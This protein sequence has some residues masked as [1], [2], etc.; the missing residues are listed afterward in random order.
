VSPSQTIFGVTLVIAL[1]SLAA[2]T[3]RKQW[4]V[5]TE[6]NA[7]ITLSPEDR[8]YYR[9]QARRRLICAVLMILLG[10]LLIASFFMEGRAEELATAMQQ[11]R[12][13]GEPRDLTPAEHTFSQVYG[14]VWI[15][16]LLLLFWLIGLAGIDYLAIRQYGKRHYKLIQ[17][18]RREMI[19]EE[20]KRYRR[21]RSEMN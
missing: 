19:R 1:F 16:A 8:V 5:L 11:A 2:Y 10:A 4:R 9:K 17:D 3:G 13:R 14:S 7:D 15:A 21:E 12:E 6:A 18:E 20:L